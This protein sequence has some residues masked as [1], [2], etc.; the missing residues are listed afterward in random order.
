MKGYPGAKRNPDGGE[1][2][3]F[4]W[5]ETWR[6]EFQQAVGVKVESII[7]NNFTNIN[8]HADGQDENEFTWVYALEG[9]RTVTILVDGKERTFEQSRA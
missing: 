1:G 7:I 4:P 9:D 6:K 2:H 3:W 5:A 8:R